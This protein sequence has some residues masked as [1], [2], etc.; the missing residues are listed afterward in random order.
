MRRCARN[1]APPAPA[2][3]DAPDAAGRHIAA[4]STAAA[5]A[6]HQASHDRLVRIPAQQQIARAAG[7]G[8]HRCSTPA[9]RRLSPRRTSPS[10]AGQHGQAVRPEKTVAS[11][12]GPGRFCSSGP[13][14]S[15]RGADEAMDE[16]RKTLL[17]DYMAEFRDH[18]VRVQTA[19]PRQPKAARTW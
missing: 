13:R 2:T 7:H 4:G 12:A 3:A 8:Q 1:L 14:R 11:S 5:S 18:I 6:E 16:S 19:L 15:S 10:T 17:P 9:C